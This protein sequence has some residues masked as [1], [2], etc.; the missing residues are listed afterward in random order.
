MNT[1]NCFVLFPLA[2]ALTISVVSAESVYQDPQ[3]RFTIAVPQGWSPS[4]T[5]GS[6]Q[7][8]RGNAFVTLFWIEGNGEAQGL[9]SEVLQQFSGQWKNVQQVG[10]SPLKFGGQP[11]NAT[12]V[13]GITPKGVQSFAAVMAAA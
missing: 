3:R 4:A 12:V 8:A 6:L 7:L 13:V 1:P 11:G 5:E 10:S 2:A 9:V